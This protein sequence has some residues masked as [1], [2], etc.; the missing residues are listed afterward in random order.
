MRAAT[1]TRETHTLPLLDPA[2]LDFRRR[3]IRKASA[4][5][6]G[7][8]V[9][10]DARCLLVYG[11]VPGTLGLLAVAAYFSGV[12]WL[13]SAVAP[14]ENREYSVLEITQLAILGLMAAIAARTWRAGTRRGVRAA[15]AAVALLCAF[16][17]LEEM[18]YGLHFVD[19]WRGSP[20]RGMRSLHGAGGTT[21]LIK[22]MVDVGIVVLFLLAPLAA[23]RISTPMLRRLIPT[24]YT[25]MTVV[26]MVAVSKFAHLLHHLG[27]P[28][29]GVLD[30]NISEFREVFIYYLAFLYLAH[31]SRETVLA[32][33][34]RSDGGYSIQP[35]PSTR[36][37]S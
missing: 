11:V 4:A 18:D 8:D 29:N 36:S 37:P 1:S 26:V 28:S 7:V 14:L 3:R 31:L 10:V 17:L 24:R 21:H 35:P 9:R 33:A 5:G 12:S 20:A 23:N 30:G 32:D 15:W 19:L 27:A 16:V 6:T 2:T 34:S 22:Q 25:M 13:Q